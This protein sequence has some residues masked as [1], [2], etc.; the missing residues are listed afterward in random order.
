MEAIVDGLPQPLS[1][2][3]MLILSSFLL[4]QKQEAVSLIVPTITFLCVSLIPLSPISLGI[5]SHIFKL[6]FNQMSKWLF[7]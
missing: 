5:S 7:F 3:L 1:S 4:S 2:C 6:I